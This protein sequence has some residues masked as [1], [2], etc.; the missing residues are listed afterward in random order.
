MLKPVQK[1]YLLFGAVSLIIS[2]IALYLFSK[3][4]LPYEFQVK[5]K[6]KLDSPTNKCLVYHDLNNDGFEER[7]SF[8]NDLNNQFYYV[9]VYQDYK[10]GLIDQFNF[11]NRIVLR[12]FVFFDVN[13]DGW[14]DVLIFTY[15]NEALYLS[16]VDVK[17]TTFVQKEQAI[18]PSSPDRARQNWD[19][20]SINARMVSFSQNQ[21]PQLLFALNSGYAKLPRCLCLYDL[22]RRKI[23]KRFDHHMG[24]TNF[25][26][27]DLDNDGKKEIVASSTATNN[28]EKTVSLSDFYAWFVVLNSN[29]KPIKKPIPLGQKFAVSMLFPISKSALLYAQHAR[30]DNLLVLFDS[31]YS[32]SKK[33]RLNKPMISVTLNSTKDPPEICV[34]TNEPAIEVRDAYLN[35]KR[36]IT[37]IPKNGKFI[38]A[39]IAD[40]LP[41]KNEEFL[42]W[43]H[44]GIYFYD[45]RFKLIAHY[46]FSK[47]TYITDLYVYKKPGAD[48]PFLNFSDSEY[49]Y[50]LAMAPDPKFGKLYLLFFLLLTGIFTVSLG[51][52]WGYQKMRQFVSYFF[53]SLKESDNAILLLNH[54]GR[55]VSVNKKVNTF[56][57]LKNPL[58]R[59]DFFEKALSQRP[60]IVEAVKQCQASLQQVKKTFSFED[61]NGSFIGE[62]TV[63]PFSGIFNFPYA[64]LVEIKD[65]T[66]HVLL[67]RQLN[68][69]RNVRKMVH[70]IKTPLGGVQLKLQ[71]LY[72]KLSNDHPD[73]KPELYE[74]LEEAYSELRRIRN[75]SKDFLKFSDLER[76][77]INSIDLQSFVRQCLE[78]FELYTNE[79]LHI[80]YYIDPHLPQVVYWDER[81]IELLLHILIENSLDALEGMGEINIEIK[82]S[83]KF[84]AVAEPWVEIRVQDNGPGIPEEHLSRVFEPHFSTKK[85]GSGLGLSFAKHIVQQHGGEINI[86]S[87][88]NSGTLVLVRLP[89]KIAFTS[90]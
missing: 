82:P 17:N 31:T 16:I 1:I 47:N 22:H 85:E 3:T 34:T 25:V 63:T 75:I 12:N 54:T 58:H 5:A 83:A 14:K 78:P 32:L 29:L 61:A 15:N 81:Q 2:L 28:F 86:L 8:T 33:I 48:F 73:L 80:N 89:E 26:V 90:S 43:T 52:F 7:L 44:G 39:K 18:L 45:A 37:G 69:Q 66:K 19:I 59:G 9:K 88:N 74:E 27:V 13:N 60:E 23:V 67:E 57:R 30:D 56:L 87:K 68:W 72:L 51:G 10:E 64:Y 70:D 62:V 55:I 24:P 4:I 20:H 46:P 38:I 50:N 79:F 11:N 35:L 41:D 21:A 76:L 65:S 42:C 53:F 36:K 71:T 84:K 77:N 40:L 49:V 6:T